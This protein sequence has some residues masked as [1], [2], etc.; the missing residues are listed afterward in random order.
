M[1]V[2]CIDNKKYPLS[3]FTNP[4]LVPKEGSKYTVVN[5]H[6]SL[7]GILYYELAECGNEDAWLSECFVPVSDIDETETEVYKQLQTQTA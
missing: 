1:Q 7:T 5:N 2:I 4:A 3:E 6:Y